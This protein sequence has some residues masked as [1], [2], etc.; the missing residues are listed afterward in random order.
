MRAGK[1]LFLISSMAVC[2]QGYAAVADLAYG[3]YLAG[4]C[5]ACH[6]ATLNA[7]IPP[8]DALAAYFEQ[9]GQ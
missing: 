4:A 6:D 9:R 8:I 3:D 2:C 7:A 1:G 5:V